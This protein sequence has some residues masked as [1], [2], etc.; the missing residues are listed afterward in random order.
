MA[1]TNHFPIVFKAQSG[2]RTHYCRTNMAKNQRLGKSWAY[3]KAYYYYSA[4]N[5]K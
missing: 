3:M 1:V 5:K 4:K 2:N